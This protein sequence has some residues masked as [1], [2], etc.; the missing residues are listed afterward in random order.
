MRLFRA[1]ILAISVACSP[2]IAT[3]TQAPT[4]ASATSVGSSPSVAPPR[5]PPA[6]PR[7]MVQGLDTSALGVLRGDWVF[8]VRETY[9]PASVSVRVEVLAVPLVDQGAASRAPTVVAAYLKSAGGVTLPPKEVLPRQFSADGRRLVLGTPAG[10]VLLELET[11]AA[12][13]LANGQNPVWGS[14]ERI[15]F[16]RPDPGSLSGPATTWLVDAAGGTPRESFCGSALAWVF[17]GSACVR[18]A[19][20]GIQLESPD[21]PGMSAIG[22]SLAFDSAPAYEVPIAVRPQPGVTVLA[23]ASTDLPAGGAGQG[24]RG[25]VAYG[26]RI[27]VLSTPGAGFRTVVASESGRFTEIRFAEPRWNPRADQIL[28]RIEGSRR[29]ET[30]VA[31]LGTKQDVVARISGIARAAEWTPNGEQIVYLTDP[32]NA[33]GPAT[34]VRAVRPISG[35]ND[36]VLLSSGGDV[37]ATFTSIATRAYD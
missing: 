19:A 17:D 21:A 22:W 35:R 6:T 26:H 30:H 29:R 8:A 2:Q 11:G 28:Y 3:P 12:R 31:D 25:D 5:T 33:I 14:G 15:A 1:L 34:E 36:R 27:E 23:V 13:L 10:I 20:G 9:V 7:S 37:R 18:G 24:P 32:Q 4:S 16:V